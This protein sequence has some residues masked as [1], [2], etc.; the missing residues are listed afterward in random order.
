MTMIDSERATTAA[1]ATLA[2]HLRSCDSDA[3]RWRLIAEFLDEFRHETPFLEQSL[4][5]DEPPPTT[6]W[7]LDLYL[8]ALTEHLVCHDLPSAKV[9]A[10]AHSLSAN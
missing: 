10:L 2:D 8:A 4:L 5:D 3:V 9:W 1:V 7:R 6:S